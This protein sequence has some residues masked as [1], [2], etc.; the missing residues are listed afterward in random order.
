MYQWL[1]DFFMEPQIYYPVLIFSA[2]LLAMGVYLVLRTAV[3]LLRRVRTFRSLT[4]GVGGLDRCRIANWP[5]VRGLV[6]LEGEAGI[7]LAMNRIQEDSEDLFHGVWIPAPAPYLKTVD[8]LPPHDAWLVSKEA[9]LLAPV[10]GA[11][12]S[13]ACFLIA[14][15]FPSNLVLANRIG[16]LAVD[17]SFPFLLGL[18]AFVV[19]A[20]VLLLIGRKVRKAVAGFCSAIG[21]KVPIFS[22]LAG[23]AALI[24]SFFEYDRR[25][26]ASVSVLNDSI[27]TLAS[28]SLTKEI[29]A[30]AKDIMERIVAPAVREASTTMEK[31]ASEVGRSQDE[32]MRELAQKFAVALSDDF[33]RHL[34]PL[35]AKFDTATLQL[36]AAQSG[37]GSMLELLGQQREETA[38]LLSDVASS[39]KSLETIR[40]G[41][42][43]DISGVAANLNTLSTAADRMAALF[44][45][46][47]SSLSSAIDTM[48]TS[49]NTMSERI[50][51]LLQN[52]AEESRRTGEQAVAA[53]SANEAHLQAMQKQIGVLS[54]ELATRF[55]QII[56]GFGSVTGETLSGLKETL[57]AQNEDFTSNVKSLV[58]SMEEESRSMSL[59]AK[60][61]G[62]DLT[63]LNH[64]FQNSVSDFNQGMLGE[65]QKTLSAFDTGLAEIVRRLSAS[66]AEIGDAVETLPQALRGIGTR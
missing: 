21:R 47:E 10:V 38:T 45:G 66:A 46:S 62:M 18:V 58:E 53:L 65:I 64:T 13:A 11:V 30:A 55:D 6:P 42:L 3:V 41:F 50:E 5:E 39:Q 19:R 15:V 20:T 37:F 12:L 49:M 26:S 31:V 35:T 60:E 44:E 28:G 25:M 61:I 43:V 27:E 7:D 48:A 56:V 8:L 2:V 29:V 63:E 33:V 34:E 32:G 24:D 9:A 40:A 52:S 59:Y 4:K 1:N 36:T 16:D 22:E 51:T 17:C 54:D 23:T 57:G 14:Y